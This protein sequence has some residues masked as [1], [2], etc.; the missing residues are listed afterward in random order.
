MYVS[1]QKHNTLSLHALL[2]AAES[3][4]R[5]TTAREKHMEPKMFETK[6]GSNYR[7]TAISFDGRTLKHVIEVHV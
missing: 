2:Q 5:C 7:E 3:S 6:H 4:Q 1:I